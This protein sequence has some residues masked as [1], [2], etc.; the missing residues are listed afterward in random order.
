MLVLL[1]VHHIGSRF[2]QQPDCYLLPVHI[3]NTRYTLHSL[4]RLSVHL[5]LDYV[6]YRSSHDVHD[7][8]QQHTY[9]RTHTHTHTHTAPSLL[10]SRNIRFCSSAG[11]S[12]G[13]VIIATVSSSRLGKTYILHQGRAVGGGMSVPIGNHGNKMC[14]ASSIQG[15]SSTGGYTRYACTAVRIHG[16]RIFNGYTR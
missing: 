8:P 3:H 1:V 11:R 5:P 6:V 14:F 10:T 7:V 16:G 2:N 9:T 15:T 12:S 4:S 13:I